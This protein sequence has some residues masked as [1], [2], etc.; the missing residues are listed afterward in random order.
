MSINK[1]TLLFSLLF[2][3][4]SSSLL[5]AQADFTL[6]TWNIQDFGRTKD[7]SEI[8]SIAKIIQTYDIIAIQEV[9]AGYGGAQAVAKLSEQL[10][11]MGSKWDYIISDPT[12]SPPY[13]TERYAYIWK[14]KHIKI[15]SR[16]RL[17]HEL[18]GNIDREPFLIDFY[19]NKKK[20]SI[21]N[22]F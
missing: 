14:T 2:I 5:H 9:V 6:L 8:N 10:N 21:I 4:F 3:F 19:I 22:F 7:S 11:R 1:R 17:I 18:S 16:G 15:K 13:M 20:F 12:D